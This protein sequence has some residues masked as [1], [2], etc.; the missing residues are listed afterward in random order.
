MKVIGSEG[1]NPTLR[2]VTFDEIEKFREQVE[3]IDMM[4]CEDVMQIAGMIKELSAKKAISSCG[5]HPTRTDVKALQCEILLIPTIQVAE[6]SRIELDKAGY[7]VIIPQP[8][9]TKLL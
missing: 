7:F 1:K 2:N 9:K 6:P 5:C 3:L 8:K 4:G